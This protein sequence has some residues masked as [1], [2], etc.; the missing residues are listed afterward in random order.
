MRVLIYQQFHPGHHY[1]YLVP[2]I[3]SLLSLGCEITIAITPEGRAS[4][5]FDAYL[6]PF[7][8]DVTFDSS[9]PSGLPRMVKRQHWQL[10]TD[11]RRAV[12]RHKPSHVLIPSGDPHTAV[13]GLFRLVGLG[14]LPGRV[15]AEIGIHWGRGSAAGDL[16][17]RTK[18]FLQ[19][20]KLGVSGWDRIHLVNFLL[21]E[22]MTAAGGRFARTL[23]LMPQPV[24]A[25]P[26]LTHTEG[27][28]SMS[29]PIEGNLVCVLGAIDER[30]AIR[31]TVLAF[32]NAIT[33]PLD[34]LLLAGVIDKRHLEF[35]QSEANDLIRSEQLI[36]RDGFVPDDQYFRYLSASNA[37]VLPYKGFT[38]LSA[39]LFEAI[40]AG[41]PVLAHRW[42]W[43][44]E[45]IRRFRL[46]WT[47]DVT[48]GPAYSDCLRAIFSGA[49]VDMETPAIDRLIQFN[50]PQNFSASWLYLIA[51][52]TARAGAGLPRTW[53]W[54]NQ[55]SN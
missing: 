2:L 38:G 48:D 33:G 35:I 40:A 30:K 34:R 29:L 53:E 39:V 17:G 24:P 45:L 25:I 14:P 13:M 6:K 47:C 50:T 28:T 52:Q 55:G 41:R 42:D 16:K 18:D 7:V 8:A 11:V 36:V 43:S 1:R 4:R 20:V 37:V 32:R 27:R 26:R 46:G 54:V 12:S 9:L 21:Y 22:R 44:E 49:S 51:Q 31:E 19:R 10:H 3:P 23:V 15:P 5:E